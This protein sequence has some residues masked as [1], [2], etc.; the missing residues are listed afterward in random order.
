MISKCTGPLLARVAQVSDGE[1]VVVGREAQQ[2]HYAGREERF[3][4]VGISSLKVVKSGRD[5]NQTLQESFLRLGLDQPDFFPQ[6]VGFEELLHVEVLESNF[7][8]LFPL[9]R[10]HHAL[11]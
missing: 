9:C 2:L 3:G 7:E 11:M 1:P 8:F 4:T 10:I 6:F 5:L